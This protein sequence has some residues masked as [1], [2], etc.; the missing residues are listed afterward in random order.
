MAILYMKIIHLTY[1]KSGYI[2]SLVINKP[3]WLSKIRR[4]M[5]LNMQYISVIILVLILGISFARKQNPGIMAILASG[6]LGLLGGMSVSD[7]LSGFDAAMFFSLAGVM[8]LF[9]IAHGN[10]TIEAMAKRIIKVAG[11]NT[12]LIPLAIWLATGIM[13][14]IGPGNISVG[15]MMTAISV[16]LAVQMGQNPMLY[17]IAAK[18]GANGFGITPLTPAGI[19]NQSIGG[20][21]GYSSFA[22]PVMLN[23]LLWSL[24]IV[25]IFYAYYHAIGER[26]A[27]ALNLIITCAPLRPSQWATLIGICMMG[28]LVVCF[29]WHIGLVSFVISALLLLLGMGDGEKTVR[30]MPWGV[31]LT[32]CGVSMLMHVVRLSG[33]VDLMTEYLLM[34]VNEANG[35]PLLSV[36]ASILS[37]FSS[38]TGVVMPTLLPMLEGILQQIDAFSYAELSSVVIT[39]SFASAFSPAS[40]GG[41]LILA[42]YAAAVPCD[43]GQPNALFRRL[44]CICAACIA[45]NILFSALR[46]YSFIR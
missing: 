14:G 36:I 18:V 40:T 43:A 33:G 16:S 10:G 6:I 1:E 15:A 42:A 31:L 11:K 30:Q 7:I 44:L 46:L 32:I 27:P 5:G 29:S 20:A 19:L 41:G 12:R 3:L 22:I 24:A 28:L 35:A 13:A 37:L 34:I 45:I 26:A 38:T 17:A 9:S 21:M 39:G 23:V 4:N 8:L 2:L 25:L